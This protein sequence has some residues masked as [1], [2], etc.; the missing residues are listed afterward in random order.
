MTLPVVSA[1]AL[2]VILNAHQSQ[3]LST[4]RC[5]Q[6]WIQDPSEYFVCDVLNIRPSDWMSYKTDALERVDVWY[7][8]TNS[9]SS[10]GEFNGGK[11]FYVGA[12]PVRL[13]YKEGFPLA[14]ENVDIANLTVEHP[15]SE[16]VVGGVLV[17][18]ATAVVGGVVVPPATA[19]V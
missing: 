3:L 16:A 10:N 13:Q 7:V 19:V 15:P 6:G 4:R 14:P 1:D 17:P 12:A 5:K 8:A 2:V 9:S 18:P 11:C